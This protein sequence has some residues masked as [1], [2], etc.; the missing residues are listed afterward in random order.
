VSFLSFFL[1]LHDVSWR[2]LPQN[3]LEILHMYFPARRFAEITEIICPL[4]Y[5]RHST[6]L[7]KFVRMRMSSCSSHYTEFS[8][9]ISQIPT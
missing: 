8:A 6:I 2:L 4:S 3:V 1:Q 9:L 5:I 7:I